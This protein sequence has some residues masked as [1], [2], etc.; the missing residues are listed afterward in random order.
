MH[1]F[2][3]LQTDEGNIRNIDLLF[4]HLRLITIINNHFGSKI[5]ALDHFERT[6]RTKTVVPLADFHP[7]PEGWASA[8][9]ASIQP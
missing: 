1:I 3:I 4:I 2:I 5:L 7:A 9:S 6:K 8:G